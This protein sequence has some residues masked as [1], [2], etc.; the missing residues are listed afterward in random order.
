VKLSV[1][2]VAGGRYFRAGEN[3]P[4]D[5]VS[6]EIAQFAVSEND[7]QPERTEVCPPSEEDAKPQSS[8]ARRTSKQ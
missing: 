8:K 6:P 2:L 5:Q 1:N 3:V 7:S 4:D